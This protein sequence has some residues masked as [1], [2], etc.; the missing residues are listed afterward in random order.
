MRKFKVRMIRMMTTIAMVLMRMTEIRP[1]S[2]F[3]AKDTNST[4]YFKRKSSAEISGNAT[5][6]LLA[7][8]C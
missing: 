4:I 1:T 6:F 3:H 8:T 7:F 5:N 2:K